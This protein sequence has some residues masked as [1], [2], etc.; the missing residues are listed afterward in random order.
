MRIYL[1]ILFWSASAA[2]VVAQTSTNTNTAPP[3]SFN[4]SGACAL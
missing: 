1:H 3:F 2:S 4:V